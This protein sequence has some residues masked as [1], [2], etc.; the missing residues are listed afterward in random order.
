MKELTAI[1]AVAV[2]LCGCGENRTRDQIRAELLETRQ[3]IVDVEAKLH[4]TN[5]KEGRSIRAI[6]DEM[7]REEFRKN[8]WETSSEIKNRTDSTVEDSILSLKRHGEV[9]DQIKDKDSPLGKEFNL[10]IDALGHGKTRGLYKEEL[11]SLDAKAAAL[12]KELSAT[13]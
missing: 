8:G 7:V 10:R 12:E 13:P 5:E 6:H 1:V 4:E 2:C 3:R 9:L 11:R